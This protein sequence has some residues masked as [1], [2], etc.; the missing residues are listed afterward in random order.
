MGGRAR[1]QRLSAVDRQR[2]LGW[3]IAA[4]SAI[5]WSTAGFFTRL[6]AEDVDDPVLARRVRGSGDRG[7]DDQ[8]P[9]RGGPVSIR[10]RSIA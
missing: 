3:L 4:L 7:G 9:S 1:I 6:I 5:A 2:Y 8:G 10:R